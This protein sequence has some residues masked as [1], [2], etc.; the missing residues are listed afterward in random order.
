MK[1]QY[2]ETIADL[3]KQGVAPDYVIGWASGFLGN[4]K[5]EEQR[6][7]EPYKAGYDDGVNK[8]IVNAANWKT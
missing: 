1:K 5:V 4:P 8:N 6:I 2:Y 3:Q 7:T